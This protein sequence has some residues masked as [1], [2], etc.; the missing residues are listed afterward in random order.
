MQRA[1]ELARSKAAERVLHGKKGKKDETQKT[2]TTTQKKGKEV[3]KHVGKSVKKHA[4]N[5]RQ[6]K[7]SEK[8]ADMEPEDL[9]TVS[10]MEAEAA[11]DETVSCG[12]H[13]AANYAAC[14][15][16]AGWCNG[17]CTWKR[18][19][20]VSRWLALSP[21]NPFGC[22]IENGTMSGRCRA[23]TASVHFNFGR[24]SNARNPIWY[25]NEVYPIQGSTDTYYATNT[26]GYGYAGIQM[27]E[28][29]ARG[30]FVIC[31]IWDQ[32]AG[33]ARME[34]CGEGVRCTGFGGEGT[35]AKSM[36]PFERKQLLS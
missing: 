13:R 4:G 22:L 19:Q 26:F 31:S 28:K 36:W 24:P 15:D 20:C 10:R 3:K 7:K 27:H 29:G 23:R 11:S 2:T 32:P 17:D 25:Y 16:H 30:S 33:P 9:T 35:G 21:E 18:D 1:Q 8:A 12:G 14:G 34:T 5:A 6:S